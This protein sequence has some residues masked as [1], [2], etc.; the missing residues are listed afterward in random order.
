VPASGKL[1][2]KNHESA[3]NGL[4]ESENLIIT[5]FQLF[6]KYLNK[7]ELQKLSQLTGTK[8]STNS[9]TSNKLNLLAYSLV[10]GSGNN[11]LNLD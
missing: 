4:S 8:I 6:T 1:I 7:F 5:N 3:S 9:S 11:K 10:G 2:F